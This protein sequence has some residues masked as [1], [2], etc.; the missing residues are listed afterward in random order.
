MIYKYLLPFYGLPLY[1][2]Y[3]IFWWTKSFNFHEFQFVYFLMLLL[4]F[5][6][7]VQ[8]NQI[9]C[10]EDFDVF[11]SK[12]TIISSLI[13]RSWVNFGVVFGHGIRKGSKLIFFM[14]ISS[15]PS[16]ICWKACLFPIEQSW[17]PLLKIIWPYIQGYI[18]GYCSLFHWSICLSLY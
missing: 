6:C 9:Q 11:S 10:H 12:S 17:P 5:C 14:Q 7:H 1:S 2:V 3:S 16:I 4:V 13:F 15:F 18:S 8:K